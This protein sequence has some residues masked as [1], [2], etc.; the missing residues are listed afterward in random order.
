ME[1]FLCVDT[2]NLQILKVLMRRGSRDGTFSGL[3]NKRKRKSGELLFL[4]AWNSRSL[5][6]WRSSQFYTIG[7][8]NLSLF[9]RVIYLI[10]GK[11]GT[12]SQNS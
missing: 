7:E 1:V 2:I 9:L 11:D 10:N 5:W 12:R 8:E 6:S 4:E 3:K